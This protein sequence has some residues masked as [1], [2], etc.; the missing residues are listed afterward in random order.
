MSALPPLVVTQLAANLYRCDAM[1]F[2]KFIALARVRKTRGVHIGVNKSTVC[3]ESPVNTKQ[4][5]CTPLRIVSQLAY[6]LC[7]GPGWQN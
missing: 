4:P 1:T 7:M 5:G 3:K 2:G 6:N